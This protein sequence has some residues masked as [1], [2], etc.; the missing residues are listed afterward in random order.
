M[1]HQRPRSAEFKIHHQ[2]KMWPIVG[3]LGLR[4]V[5]KSTLLR[6]RIGI[7]QYVTLD[8]EDVRDE[9]HVSAKNFL[10]RYS[11][12]PFVID[13]VQKEPKLF[14]ALKAAVDR[15]KIPGQWLISGSVA[16]SSKIGIRESLTGRIGLT[17]LYPMTLSEL[18]NLEFHRQKTFQIKAE[19]HTKRF[20][21][22]ALAQQMFRGGLPV[23]AFLRDEHSRHEYWK[24]WTDTTIARDAAKAYGRGFDVEFCYS[25]LKSMGQALSEAEYPSLVYL[26]GDKRKCKKYIQALE[27]I[28]ILQRWTVD[29]SGVGNDHWTFGDSGMAYYFADKKSGSGLQLSIARHALI[30]EIYAFLE[31]NSIPYRRNYF[32][33][34][35]GAVIDFVIDS[36]P[37]RVVNESKSSASFAYEER[38]LAGA[39]K[40]LSSEKGFLLA[41]IENAHIPKKGIGILPWTFFS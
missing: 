11:H 30:T 13:E 10:A 2:R 21:S 23:P 17:H 40:A 3:V 6:D 9:A 4:Q 31:Y 22:E 41:P 33:S 12:H 7:E 37:F 26:S 19:G 36:I 24:N 38:A 20:R 27:D 16:F 5:G 28:F 18:H 39:M 32:K 8:D 14:D 35:K 1:P 34:E 25:L 29:A 15:K